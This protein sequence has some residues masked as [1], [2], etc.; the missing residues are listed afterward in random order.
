M[1]FRNR[2]VGLVRFSYPSLTGFVRQDEDSARNIA[3]LYDRPRLE[4]RFQLFERYA[5]PSLKAQTD[6]GFETVVLVGERFPD[7]AH[8]RLVADLAD[9]P[10]AQIVALPPMQ[11]Y[12]ATQAAFGMV[13]DDDCTHL[14]SF[15]LDDDDAIDIHHVARL[16]RMADGMLRVLD[17][18][19]PFCI[20]HN[21]GLFLNLSGP[22]STWTEVHEKLPL[23]VGLAMCAPVARRENIFRRNHRLLSMFYTTLTDS[24]AVA[25]IRTIHSGNDS[26]AKPSGSSKEIAPA[27]L[28]KVLHTSF[29]FLDPEGAA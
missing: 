28:A 7:W 2:I 23:G 22:T 14:T 15:R 27:A 6:S 13:P 1:E 9:L 21:R 8:R 18:G 24:N 10:G 16:R 26:E 4:A 19:K 20:G 29:P 5:L 17:P 3:L 11:H 25:Y 12:P